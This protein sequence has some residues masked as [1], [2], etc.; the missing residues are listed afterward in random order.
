M[1]KLRELLGLSEDATD[2]QVVG[3]LE[4]LRNEKTRLESEKSTL[5]SKN[6]ELS[7]SVEGL[8]AT[9]ETLKDSY[10]ALV[11]NQDNKETEKSDDIMLELAKE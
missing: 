6:Q 9:N 10:R 7:A 11:E 2:E 8:K 3:K 5:E 1:D 4:E